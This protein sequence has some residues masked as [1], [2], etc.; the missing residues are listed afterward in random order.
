MLSLN[1]STLRNMLLA[2]SAAIPRDSSSNPKPLP[3]AVLFTPEPNPASY[4]P[5]TNRTAG[6]AQPEAPSDPALAAALSKTNS[7]RAAYQVSALSWDD[8]LAA[9]AAAYVADCPKTNSAARGV[10]EN[11]AW[12]VQLASV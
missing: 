7:L 1:M 11:M 6:F 8:D 2:S 4:S 10:G 9:Q 12:W 3:Y 5:V